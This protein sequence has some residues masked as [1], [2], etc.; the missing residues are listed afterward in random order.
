MNSTSALVMHR[1][2]CRLPLH[3]HR[4]GLGRRLAEPS[5]VLE[6]A[7]TTP[8]SCCVVVVQEGPIS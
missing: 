1:A 2:C 3:S 6:N 7:S 5:F 4:M 8:N